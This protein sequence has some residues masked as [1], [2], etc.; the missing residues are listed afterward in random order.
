M[1]M[2]SAVGGGKGDGMEIR[3][4]SRR[5][6]DGGNDAPGVVSGKAVDGRCEAV[7]LIAALGGMLGA[8]AGTRVD[9]GNVVEFAGSCVEVDESAGTCLEPAKG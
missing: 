1:S 9:E 4:L 8:D 2:R 3:T 5:L 7:W 6:S